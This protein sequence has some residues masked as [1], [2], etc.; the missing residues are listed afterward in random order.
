MSALV[1]VISQVRA[2]TVYRQGAMVTRAAELARDGDGFPAR[3]QLVGLPLSLDDSSLRVELEA[4]QPDGGTLPIAGDLRVTLS[5]PGHNPELAP[6]SNAELEQAKLDLA[7]IGGELEQLVRAEARLARLQPIGRGRPEEG[8]PPASSP[9]AARLELLG[10]RRERSEQLADQIRTLRE[11][12]R[13]AK[14]WLAT[15]RERERI[16]STQ[17][18]TRTYE[19][20]KAAVLELDQCTGPG[21]V[22][23]VRVK[24]HYFVP[25]ARWAP[26][27]TVRLDGSM[28]TGSLELH[29]LVGQATGE[30]WRGVALTLSTAIPQQWTELPKL[31][32]QRIG[33]RQPPPTKTGWRPPPVGADQLY[34]D[35]D[36]GLGQPLAAPEPELD[37]DSDE[38]VLA[39][40]PDDEEFNLDR[41]M[42]EEAY[43]QAVPPPA[44]PSYAPAPGAPPPMPVSAAAPMRA[45]ST[46]APQAEMAKRSG[47]LVGALVGGAV[48]AVAAAAS[49]FGGG[50]GG[51]GY[52]DAGPAPAEAEA[53][54]LAGR[55][56]LDYGRLRL[57]APDHARRGSLRRIESRVLYQQLS[58]ET[59]AIDL[60][61]QQ[62]DAAV[63]TARRL[64]QAAVPEG[65]RWP[66][67]K[68]GFDYAYVADAPCDLASDGKFHSLAIDRREAEATPRYISVPR[69]TQDVFRIVALRNPLAA[70]LL[71]GPAD[72][73]VAGKFALTTP[74]E[75]T[76]IG[77]RIELGLGVEQAIKI[78]RNISFAEDSAG[79][80]KRQLELRHTIAIEIANHLASAATVEVRERVPI[81][82]DGQDDV[83]VTIERVDPSW[84]DY[85]PKDT[86][87]E[88]GRR[89]VVEVPAN[90][91]RELEA[92]WVA[93]IPT[94]HELIG[95]NRREV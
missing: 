3:V 73:Y 85:E 52:A 63:A 16:A 25:G 39:D 89:W 8:K 2:V 90:G 33:R 29:A 70:P 10:F 46:M 57:H 45:R 55:D 93:T 40:Q 76:P 34:A 88:G 5:V 84:E 36:R 12:E 23:R 7:L 1:D 78:A 4:V 13:V 69:E 56:L 31:E 54:L 42:R 53:E 50:E 75:L 67:S 21:L 58:V 24:L 28:R 19:L 82:P 81:V 49:A 87:L 77:G 95:G 80:F 66:T 30:D 71:P 48:G 47:G 35:F 62:I 43:A 92:T 15:L 83:E 26:S 37:D 22:E 14:E 94:N 20:R 65:H 68:G 79:M 51:G 60:A 86:P 72:V 27:Y 6:P 64:E 18:N 41:L 74:V 9:T 11:R 44:P 59:F 17:K 38:D 91:K 32:S 61:V